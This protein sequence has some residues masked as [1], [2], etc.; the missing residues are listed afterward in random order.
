[1]R[2]SQFLLA[3]ASAMTI[4]ALLTGRAFHAQ[5]PARPANVPAF[6]VA[7]VKPNKSDEVLN[8]IGFQQGGRFTATNVPLRELIRVAFGIQ[9]FQLIGGPSWIG[10]ERFDIVAKADGD[11]PSGS[12]VVMIRRLLAE[13]FKL[14]AH[15]E[16]RTLQLYALVMADADRRLGPQL[17]ASQVDCAV[18]MAS[19]RARSG[20]PSGFPQPGERQLCDLFVGFPPLFS[21][22]GV[23]MPQLATSLSRVVRRVVIDQ[24]GLS[25]TF[26]FDLQWTPEGL[27]QRP[28]DA[29][30]PARLNGVD[31]DPNGPSIF[32]ALR[33]QLGLKLEPQDGPVDVIVIDDVSQPT[34]D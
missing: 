4:A 12:M 25:G 16:R 15:K 27:P 22:G 11:P 1:M 29:V 21:A 7:S 14:I 20:S 32:T 9:S 17:R 31:V 23:N 28:A 34:A 33:E 13:R 18:A 26:D 30:E 24:T 8:S 3:T 19:A 5:S 2:E 6:E 10:S